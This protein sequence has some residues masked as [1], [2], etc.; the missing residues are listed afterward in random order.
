MPLV[1]RSGRRRR[2][3]GMGA[4]LS[5]PCPAGCRGPRPGVG[6]ATGSGRARARMRCRWLF[7]SAGDGAR[8]MRRRSDGPAGRGRGASHVDGGCRA[9]TRRAPATRLA[10]VIAT[11]PCICINPVAWHGA[12]AAGQH[13]PCYTCAP[14]FFNSHP[15]G[16][17]NHC[18]L[19]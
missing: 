11:V 9:S 19:F 3:G 2:T 17:P 6:G 15:T 14:G 13:V 5:Y 16:Q 10:P 4:F 18:R 1:A 8:G 12:G 7:P